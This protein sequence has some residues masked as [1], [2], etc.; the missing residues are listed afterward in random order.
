MNSLLIDYI[1]YINNIIEKIEI[2]NKNVFFTALFKY[3]KKVDIP[4][5]KFII[6]K[7]W[8]YIIFTNINNLN[9]SWTI[10]NVQL[11]DNN[12]ILTNRI[13]KWLSHIFLKRYEICFYM[14]AFFIPIE[15]I[16]ITTDSIIQKTHTKRNCVYSE[17]NAC[18][19]SKKINCKS[20]NNILRYFKEK[21]IKKNIGLYHNDIFIK[22]NLN[23]NLNLYLEELINI[24]IEKKIYRDQ[25]LLP[26]IY[27]NN[28]F[29]PNLDNSIINLVEKK[30]KKI[31]YLY[32]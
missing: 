14:D 20:R 9:T 10:V 4:P 16:N 31:N 3:K 18:L 13:Y 26:I 24:M 22:N 6:N 29:K 27:I 28:N 32:Y 15:N 17:L 5:S 19:T 11:F 30:G 2:N 25:L 12:P 8:D 23:K 1:S 7:D 21:K